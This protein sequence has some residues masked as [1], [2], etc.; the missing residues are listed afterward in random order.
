MGYDPNSQ[1][2]L[3]LNAGYVRLRITVSIPAIAEKDA[4]DLEVSLQQLAKDFPGSVIEFR[5]YPSLVGNVELG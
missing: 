5:R 2:P 1:V 4:E 3:D